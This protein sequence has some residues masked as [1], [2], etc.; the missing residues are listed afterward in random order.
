MWLEYYYTRLLEVRLSNWN[1]FFQQERK[2]SDCCPRPPFPA[3]KI[4][5]W[6]LVWVI[7]RA[8]VEQREMLEHILTLHFLLQ[9]LRPQLLIWA[10]KIRIYGRKWLEN[11]REWLLPLKVYCQ[12]CLLFA[13]FWIE[14]YTW[15]QCS[16]LLSERSKFSKWLSGL[17]P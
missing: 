1:F 7:L 5:G 17:K 2:R 13:W 14:K 3:R 9:I 10:E 16:R 8:Q 12:L 15:C 6:F 11:W 4:L